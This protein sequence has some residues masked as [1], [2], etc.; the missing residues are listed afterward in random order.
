M[1]GIQPQFQVSTFSYTKGWSL[2]TPSIEDAMRCEWCDSCEIAKWG[3]NI[4][5]QSHFIYTSEVLT[6]LLTFY[7]N[8]LRFFVRPR[9]TELK[10]KWRTGWGYATQN[11]RHYSRAD[12]RQRTVPWPWIGLELGTWSWNGT[13]KVGL[14]VFIVFKLCSKLF[15]EIKLL[16]NTKKTTQWISQIIIDSD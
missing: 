14:E 8:L 5:P 4:F 16:R 11:S 9:M 13:W 7:K 10:L 1:Q 3:K 15:F 12:R 6:G 2:S